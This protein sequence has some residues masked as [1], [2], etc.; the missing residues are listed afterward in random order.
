M[1]ERAFIT[2]G[3]RGI[4]AATVRAFRREGFDVCFTY[5][6]SEGAARALAAETG[7]LGLRCDV[8]DAGAMAA[9]VREGRTYYGAAA[10][11]VLVANAGTAY[12][13]LFGE[14][15]GEACSRVMDTNFGGALHAVRAALPDM[16]RAG[17]GSIILVSS[18]WGLRAASCEAVYSASKAALIGLGRSLAAEA[19]PSGIRVNIVAPGVIDTDMNM[20]YDRTVMDGLAERTPLGRT[21]RPEEVA[22][23]I[24]FLAS[25]KASFVSGQVLGVDGGFA[26]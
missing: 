10:F 20:I 12:A 4:G 19:G 2:G 13:G 3:S 26:V 1:P 21:G 11:D 23:A 6:R 25:A 24:L 7:A 9:A 22:E 15:S 16:I 18:V 5:L 8:R 14:M 17:R